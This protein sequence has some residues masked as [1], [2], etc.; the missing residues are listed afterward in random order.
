MCPKVGH[1]ARLPE[2]REARRYFMRAELF[3]RGGGSALNDGIASA[4]RAT[5]AGAF[6]GFA[7]SAALFGAGAG[8]T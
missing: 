5:S 8:R 7:T 2:L 1:V 6:K 3:S 4:V